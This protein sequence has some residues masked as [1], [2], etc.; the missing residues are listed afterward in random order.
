VTRVVSEDGEG[1]RYSRICIEG[2]TYDAARLVL[3]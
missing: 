2:P 1:W 3:E